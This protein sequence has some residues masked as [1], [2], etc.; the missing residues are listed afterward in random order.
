MYS[1]DYNLEEPEFR[2]YLARSCNRQG[3]I[4]EL[5][6]RTTEIQTTKELLE[7]DWFDTAAGNKGWN[8][9]LI[10]EKRI[11]DKES[12]EP[13]QLQTPVKKEPQIKKEPR[14][15]KEPQIKKEQINIQP[16]V[17]TGIS[18]QTLQLSSRKRSRTDFSFDSDDLPENPFQIRTEGSSSFPALSDRTRTTSPIGNLFSS[19]NVSI[20]IDLNSSY[21]LRN[22]YNPHSFYNPRSL[23][24]LRS[25]RSFNSFG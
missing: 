6:L 5:P 3:E 14:I 8:V 21:S 4:S 9:C 10:I 13:S 19:I 1:K 23:R 2:W 17:Q 7:N 16:S 12:Y 18:P 11:S 24:S 20:L 25:P 22:L 15:K